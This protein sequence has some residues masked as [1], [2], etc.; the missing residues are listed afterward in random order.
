MERDGAGV[1]DDRERVLA[2]GD[3][4]AG[5]RG[6]PGMIGEQGED[7]LGIGRAAEE[8]VVLVAGVGAG[9]VGLGVGQQIGERGGGVAPGDVGEPEA[10]A[11]LDRGAAR[12]Q[13]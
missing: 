12:E 1:A 10:D 9:V 7:V 6:R 3:E 11:R 5:A 8:A 2:G 13:V 4:A